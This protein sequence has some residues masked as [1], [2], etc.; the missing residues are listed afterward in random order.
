VLRKQETEKDVHYLKRVRLV[1][2]IYTA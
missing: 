2:C 1:S